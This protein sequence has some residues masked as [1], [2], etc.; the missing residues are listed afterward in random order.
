MTN[1]YTLDH[2]CLTGY[3]RNYDPI[4]QY[5]CLLPYNNTS[6]PLIV[7]QEY[8]IHYDDFLLP[9]NIPTQIV[10]PLNVNKHLLHLMIKIELTIQHS[11]SKRIPTMNFSSFLQ[12]LSPLWYKLNKK[13]NINHTLHL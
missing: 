3:L 2:S 12:R 13:L 6:C 4:K 1:M 11:T 7:P 8:L 5:F 9:C 10:K